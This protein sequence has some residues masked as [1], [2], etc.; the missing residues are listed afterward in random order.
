MPPFEAFGNRLSRRKFLGGTALGLGATVTGLAVAGWRESKANEER[1]VSLFGKRLHIPEK[2]SG[3]YS[4]FFSPVNRQL[5]VVA[6]GDYT[7]KR[8]YVTEYPPE[9][10]AS[11]RL[12]AELPNC[13]DVH[14]VTWCREDPTQLAVAA[15]IYDGL[16]LPA[17]ENWGAMDKW[18]TDKGLSWEQLNEKRVCKV[19]TVSKGAVHSILSYD[20]RNDLDQCQQMVWPQRNGIFLAR[21]H[22]IYRGFANVQTPSQLEEVFLQKKTDEVVDMYRQVAYNSHEGLLV[23]IHERYFGPRYKQKEVTGVLFDHSGKIQKE[24]AIPALSSL[25]NSDLLTNVLVGTDG[26]TWLAATNRNV[27]LT[28][29]IGSG[30]HDEIPFDSTDGLVVRAVGTS[31]HQLICYVLDVDSGFL[32]HEYRFGPLS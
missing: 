24:V 28:G 3:C 11:Y 22:G 32:R 20:A 9:S 14:A 10:P 17:F 7:L 27:I 12:A 18:R 1:Q 26:D 29:H 16:Q 5:A 21:Y 6:G 25:P 8:I 19:F 2:A 13:D 15:T 4:F 23:T 30:K 31:I